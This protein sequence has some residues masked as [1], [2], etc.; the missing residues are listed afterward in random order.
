MQR[1]LESLSS[2]LSNLVCHCANTG[3]LKLPH[4]NN[5]FSTCWQCS[6]VALVFRALLQLYLVFVILGQGEIKSG[7]KVGKIALEM[8]P[9][10]STGAGGA[11]QSGF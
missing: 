6:S 3:P 7:W 2:R 1:K 5:Q 11:V 8:G 4:R 10:C 9:S